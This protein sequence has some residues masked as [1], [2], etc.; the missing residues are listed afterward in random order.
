MVTLKQI[1]RNIT[2]FLNIQSKILDQQNNIENIM[3]REQEREGRGHERI[4]RS[5][6]VREGKKTEEGAR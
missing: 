4:G 5:G 3:V 2:L 6:H 1:L